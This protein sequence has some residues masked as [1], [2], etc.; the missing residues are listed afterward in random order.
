MLRLRPALRAPLALALLSLPATSFAGLLINPSF[1]ESYND[2]WP[3]YGALNGWSGGSGSNRADGPFHNVGTPVPDGLQIGFQQGSGTI[4]QGV[5]GLT[6][7][8]QYW[9]QFFYDARGCCGGSIDL[10]TQWDGTTLDSLPSITPVTGGAGYH[11]RNVPFTPAADSGTLAFVT[12]AAGDATLSLDAVCLVQREAGQAV[13]MNPGFEA[14]GASAFPGGLSALAGWTITGGVGLNATGE[15][16]ADNGATPEQKR[17][18]VIQS[19]GSLSQ[20]VAGLVTGETYSVTFRYNARSGNTPH[21]RVS[22]DG[23]AVFDADVTPVGGAAEY[24]AGSAQFTA[25][26]PVAQISFEQTDAGDQTV[27]LD[28]VRVSGVVVEPP[29]NLR[30]SPERFELQPGLKGTL[31][32]TVSGQ[33]LQ[34][35][36]STVKL[37]VQNPGVARF[38]AGDVD[39]I[40]TLVFPSGAGD[41]TLTAELEGTGRGSTTV[42]VVDNGGHAGVD[43]AV[44]VSGVLSSVSNPSFEAGPPPAGVGYGPIPA[45]SQSNLSS[46]G[47]NNGS[48]PFFDNG[49]TPDRAQVAFMQAGPQSVWQEVSGLQPG[50]RHWLQF[51]HNARNCC[52]GTISLT[53]RFNETD[54]A[55]IE[56]IQPV[57]LGSPFTFVNLPFTPTVASG[58]IEFATTAEGDAS[59]VIDAVCIVQR[60]EN[61]IVVKNPSFEASGVPDGVGYQSSIA[62]WTTTG[63]TGLNID[64]FGPFTDNG[65]AS[66]QDRVLFLQQSGGVSQVI[67][68]LN[69][70]QPHTLSFLVN[71][72]NCCTGPD[73]PYHVLVDGV[74]IFTSV[75]QPVG[76]GVPYTTQ[77]LPFTPAGT[78]AEIRIEGL[79]VHPVDQTLLIDDVRVFT[80]IVGPGSGTPLSITAVGGTAVDVSW[81]ASAPASLRLQWSATLLEN[82]WQDVT[83]VPF[84]DNDEYH[85]LEVIDGPVR[86]YRLVP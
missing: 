41:T 69:A 60:D 72:R 49:T 14:S 12:T 81:P 71:S 68:G 13:L 10:A 70:G 47:L 80:G 78:S 27:L 7:G 8:T 33:R 11:F 23:A 36:D 22:V 75:Q 2:V 43:G 6:A 84:V 42:E 61:E 86:F 73:T 18:A 50:K 15:D 21:L 55:F 57:G 30:L 32:V 26:A 83:E 62:G 48:M 76:V 38:V 25:S 28:D 77:W 44:R 9:V 40:V 85:V 63:G 56:N 58:T 29:P 39:G 74:E 53:V 31:S 54:L 1:E 35:G 66:A 16:F 45:W 17:V 3:H 59:L 37:R 51:F 64:T 46:S 20:T 24:L 67:D 82:S 4:S 34:D 79:T 5:S 65:I 52:G 19:L